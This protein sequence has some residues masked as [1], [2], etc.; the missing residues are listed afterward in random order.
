MHLG[1]STVQATIQNGVWEAD[2][3]IERVITQITKVIVQGPPSS[4]VN[5]Y[6]GS[7]PLDTPARGDFNANE[8]LIPL[9]MLP[10]EI[11]KVIW[12]IGNAYGNGSIPTATILSRTAGN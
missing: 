7:I 1:T 11:L 2:F 10:G 12:N 6:R 5:I 8:F 9:E 3:Q 4:F